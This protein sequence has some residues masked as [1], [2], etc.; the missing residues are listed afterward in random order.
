M[1]FWIHSLHSISIEFFG[2]K[3]LNQFLT[4]TAN[5]WA[6]FWISNMGLNFPLGC[7]KSSCD[8]ASTELRRL[9]PVLFCK[10]WNSVVCLPTITFAKGTYPFGEITSPRSVVL[11]SCISGCWNPHIFKLLRLRNIDVVI[12]KRL[13][14]FWQH[15]RVYRLL[16]GASRAGF[17]A[18]QNERRA[19]L[20]DLK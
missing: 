14:D 2:L 10:G 6:F 16:I 9:N 3:S 20:S 11:S 18:A 7:P 8:V 4:S 13:T 19:G 5:S 17:C 15:G 12:P 1:C